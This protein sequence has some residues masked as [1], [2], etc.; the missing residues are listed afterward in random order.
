VRGMT[1]VPS[2]AFAP[3]TRLA[4]LGALTQ[5]ERALCAQHP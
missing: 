4:A 5:G 1:I 2:G 3:L